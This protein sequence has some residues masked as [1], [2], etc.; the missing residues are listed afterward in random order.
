MTFLRKCLLPGMLLILGLAHSFAFDLEF[1][2]WDSLLKK[3]VRAKETG[4]TTQVLY[5]ELKKNKKELEP[6]LAEFSTV[7]QKEFDSW[8]SK[9]QL[10]FLLNA[11]NLFTWKLMVDNWPVKSIKDIGSVLKSPWKIEFYNLLGKKRSLDWLEHDVIRKNYAEP[12]VHFALNCASIGCPPLRGEAYVASKLETQLEEQTKMF[13]SNP[14]EN[15]FNVKTKKLELSEIFSWFKGDFTKKS[16][17]LPH[18]LSHYWP[19]VN[20]KENWDIK[21]KDYNWKANGI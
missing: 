3:Y 11:Y 6:V 17:S 19:E 14:K 16:K 5:T 7:N 18:W 8:D 4:K 10:A 21:F 1:K 9:N 20:P 12:R 13:L 2:S 15:S